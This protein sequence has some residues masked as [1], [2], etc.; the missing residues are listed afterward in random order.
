M[1]TREEKL[2]EI[3]N[4]HKKI[5]VAALSEML[6]VS[7]VTIRKDLTK[8][9]ERGI[10]QRQ[11]GFAQ[12]N[13]ENDMH[14][15]M[16]IN[17]NIKQNIAKIAAND[18]EEG[19]TILI[20]SGSTCALLADELSSSGKALT[21]ITNSVFIANRLRDSTKIEVILLGG[22]FQKESQVNIGALVIEMA[23]NFFVEKFYIGV[24]GYTPER[25]FTGVNLARTEVVRELSKLSQ[26]TIVLTD[27]SKFGKQGPVKLFDTQEVSRVYTDKGISKESMEHL[28]NKKI[29]VYM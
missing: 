6:N 1:M 25:G 14:F 10:I 18:I 11:H 29:K 13:N 27:S 2:I 22:I 21:I 9:E 23:R 26:E 7:E 16:S 15:R 3:I 17:F 5:E 28:I 8:L 4:E 24:D 20:E 12:I 19:A